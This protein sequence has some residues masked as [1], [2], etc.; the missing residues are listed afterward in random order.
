[1][2]EIERLASRHD[3]SRFASARPVLDDWLRKHALQA[4]ASDSA[5]TYVACEARN[6]V[7]FVSLASSSV[8]PAD[9]SVRMGKGISAHLPAPA[10]LIAR[11][12][13]ALT[14]ERR[15]VATS[16]MLHAMKTVLE[17]RKL[18]A[19]RALLVNPLDAE[20]ARFYRKFDFEDLPGVQ[21]A[22]MYLLAKDVAAS[23]RHYES[24]RPNAR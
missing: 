4:Q 13:T 23:V 11:L 12:A 16:L 1:M 18:S 24:E 6:V 8:I 10:Q 14:H 9:M 20:A 5:A 15:G 17:I 7:G 2:L 19:V 22:A 21:P 3:L